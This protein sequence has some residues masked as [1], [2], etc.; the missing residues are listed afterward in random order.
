MRFW[1]KVVKRRTQ[2][3]FQSPYLIPIGM[4]AEEWKKTV[5][6][7]VELNGI[8]NGDD[9]EWVGDHKLLEGSGGWKDITGKNKSILGKRSVTENPNFDSPDDGPIVLRQRLAESESDWVPPL[10]PGY[11]S[12][13]QE[14]V[15]HK[16]PMI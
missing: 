12:D 6:A 11:Q 16:F 10:E 2:P 7:A 14:E 8:T 9:R 15:K 4:D 3:I 1:R 13:A 5:A